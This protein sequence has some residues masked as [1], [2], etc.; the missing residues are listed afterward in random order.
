LPREAQRSCRYALIAL[1]ARYAAARR[2][3]GAH[4]PRRARSANRALARA[5]L[6]IDSRLIR[7][8]MPFAL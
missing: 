1:S 8:R 4:A 2:V 7:R 6:A 5:P 3:A